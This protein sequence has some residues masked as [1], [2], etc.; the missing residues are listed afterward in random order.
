MQ[1]SLPWPTIV[2]HAPLHAELAWRFVAWAL[3]R[4]PAS[5]HAQVR[6]AFAASLPTAP[7][8]EP[9]AALDHAL[10]RHGLLGAPVRRALQRRVHA[11]VIAPC[12]RRCSLAC[13]RASSAMGRS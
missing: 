13:P 3:E 5:L 8:A 2:K 10:A 9:V 4:A 6:Q 12:A 7:A 1:G 11:E